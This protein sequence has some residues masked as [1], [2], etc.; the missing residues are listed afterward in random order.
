MLLAVFAERHE[1][2]ATS[3]DV[4]CVA[5][6]SGKTRQRS[7]DSHDSVFR[8]A[9]LDYTYSVK[10]SKKI[11]ARFSLCIYVSMLV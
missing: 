7:A 3:V 6:Q 11:T 9:G 10:R 8:S 4:D 1:N 2:R 5:E